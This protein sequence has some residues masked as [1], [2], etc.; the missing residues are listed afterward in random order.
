MQH[1]R[2]RASVTNNLLLAAG[3]VAAIALLVGLAI[4]DR[5]QSRPRTVEAAEPLIVYCAADVL[6]PIERIAERFEEVSGVPV[7]LISQ[8]SG[9]LQGAIRNA[10]KGDVY[11]PADVSFVEQ[12]R[13]EGLARET[14]PF[15]R[16]RLVLAVRSGNPKGISSLEDLFREGVTCGV[17]V[18]QAA[19]GTTTRRVLSE[20]PG[21]WERLTDAPRGRVRETTERVVA[22]NVRDGVTDAGFMWDAVAR[23]E[24]LEIVPIPQLDAPAGG[25]TIAAGVLSMSRRPADALRFAHYLAAADKGQPIL[26]EHHFEPIAES[27]L[28]IAPPHSRPPATGPLRSFAIVA[29]IPAASS[30]SRTR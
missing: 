10:R 8:N 17:A 1:T 9:A 24:S 4:L 30:G 5:G 26:R 6:P 12:I 3:A 27:P 21:L 25:A 29:V 13:D 16:M 14:I 19:I 7:H 23:R 11:I 18:E 2:H 15:A 22:R 20:T 28:V